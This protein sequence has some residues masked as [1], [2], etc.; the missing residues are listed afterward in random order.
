M[1]F[2]FIPEW[3]LGHVTPACAMI[4]GLLEEGHT[5][6]LYTILTEVPINLSP[7]LK[8]FKNY[9]YSNRFFVNRYF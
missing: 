3:G 4:K 7:I 6:Y 5:V 1:R 8:L 2:L 9:Q